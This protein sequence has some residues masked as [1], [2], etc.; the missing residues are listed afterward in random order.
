MFK[1][2][3][4]RWKLVLLFLVVGLIPLG[5]I[6]F[7]A[8]GS[9]E[10]EIT[11]S[12]YNAMNMY[13]EL[14]DS[15]LEAFF[16]EREGDVGVL[17]NTADIYESLNVLYEEDGDI[18]A[19]EWTER[20]EQI[21]RVAASV[22]DAYV[23]DD[24]FLTD[25]E[26]Q[27]VFALEDQEI[28]GAD[29]RDRDYI[30]GSM[31]GDTSWSELFFSDVINANAMVVSQPVRSEGSS[32]EIVGTLNLIFDQGSINTAVHE[33]LEELGE[34]ADAYLIDDT[35]LLLT[36]TLIGDF[37]EGAALE[38]SINT[39][40]VEY[41]S[42]PIRNE[43]YD[44]AELDIYDEYRGEEVLG[45]LGVIELGAQPA[46]LI[47]ELDS[48]EALAGVANMGGM[49]GGM[50]AGASVLVVVVALLFSNTIV[51]P[52]KEVSNFLR[53]MAERGGDL[54][55]RITVRSQ[56]EIGELGYWFNSF[57]DKLHDIIAQ[58]RGSSDAVSHGSAE[59][60]SGN[61]DLSQRTEE[62]ASSLEEVSSTIEE[63]NSSLDETTSS[64]KEADNLATQTMQ[65]VEKGNEVVQDMQG[66]MEEI[67]KGSQ[68]IAEII[69]KVNDIS[70]QTNLLALNAAVEA[71]RAGDQG[72]GVAVVAAEVRNLAGRSAESAKEIE[73]LINDSISRVEKGNELMNN[74]ES[75]LQ[76][77]VDNTK[78]TSDIVGEISAS[79][80]EQSTAVSDI[81][82]AI[83]ELNQVTQQNASLVEEIASSSESMNSEAIEL[84]E[85]IDVFKLEESSTRSR[86]GKQ[87]TTSKRANG[88][89]NQLAAPGNGETR[90]K[91]AKRKQQELPAGQA[92]GGNGEPNID[93]Q[94]FEK[95]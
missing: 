66:A 80:G 85:L 87:E 36:D 21:E 95:F 56:D 2:L 49:M 18:S 23:Y 51:A 65:T 22:I 90:Q 3:S 1:K 93:E 24:F 71:A 83:E 67:T 13:R 44:Y 20:K 46:G 57:V 43:N 33:G 86:K 55:Q 4:L 31:G 25:D 19:E 53:D 14:A 76:E 68:E 47:V 45:A 12:A 40:A 8:Y 70:F 75:V 58:V 26:A 60:S 92:D 15:E 50:A 34:T 32:G 78:K 11:D 9:A 61:Q 89:G 79:L 38:E 5:G 82:N 69:S 39:R 72:R 62:Q 16:D 91:E 94:D 81:R 63:I 28:V 41:L 54:T 35:G 30:Q 88:E 64:A 17:A 10:D 29:L 27:G 6:S 74:T 77:I 59:I 42:D 7:M 84:G 73:K 48:A 52:V 37:Q